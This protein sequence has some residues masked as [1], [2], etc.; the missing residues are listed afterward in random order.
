MKKWIAL[1]SLSVLVLFVSGCTNNPQPPKKPVIDQTLPKL[2]E[3]KFLSEVTEV[4]FEWKPS[5][6]ERVNGY[7]VY[8][9]NPKVQNGR[10][11]RIATIKD[12]YSSHFVDTGLKPEAQ[13]YYRFSTYS[14][15]KRESVASDTIS[16]NTAPL[17]KSVVYIKAITG[18]PNRV[19]LIWRPHT[20]QRVASYIIER[21]EF[22][23][24][25]WKRLAKVKGR[26]NAEYIDAGLEEN[27]VFRYRVKVETYDG[28]ISQPS[29]IVEAGTKPLP[30]E[31]KNLNATTNI[32]KKIVLSWDASVEKDFSY[33]K[34]YR[35][36]NPMLFYSYVAKT[37]DIKYE[38][39]IN[40]NGK[41]YYYFV[42]TVDKDGLESP[43]QKNEVTGSSLAIPASVYITSSNHDGRSINITWDS[44]DKRA[45]KY[46]V[47]KEYKGK[48]K[49][50][51][52]IQ[53]KS[54]NDEDVL[55][56]IEYKYN[57]VAID[58]YG[59]A[60]KKSENTIIE[61]PKE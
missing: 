28:L 18:L 5:F 25:T 31:I 38:D 48:K 50:F 9:S 41:S 23:S 7:Y 47:I 8:R 40:A 15:N 39:L 60:S 3:I 42:T 46:S 33:Y 45:V 61:M 6:D 30:I 20:S 11:Q 4:G 43:R 10:L 14:K 34:V 27:H 13:Y 55:R 17:I 22:T 49:I 44:L 29:K 59:L 1:I 57:V 12:K 37:Q 19:K 58:K 53:G 52:G 54:F 21:N 56:G 2:T 32:P 35:A 26:L 36:I 24:T 51:T 16:V